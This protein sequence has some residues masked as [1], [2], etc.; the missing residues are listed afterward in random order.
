MTAATLDVERKLADGEGGFQ[1]EEV[2]LP[3]LTLIALE[4]PEN[5]LAPFYLS[6]I[7]RQLQDL[8]FGD[9]AQALVSS[10]SPSILSRIEPED[11]RHL[12]LVPERRTA[13]VRGIELPDGAEAAGKFVRQAVRA[14]PELYFARFVI[15]G[16]GAS[17]EIVLPKLAD[18]MGLPIDRSFVAMVPLGGRHVNHLWKLLAGL[19]I[20]YQK[21]RFQ[22]WGLT[23]L[24]KRNARH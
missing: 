11:V 15:L 12:R 2:P 19:D 6:R 14:Y 1:S 3:A 8:S 4:E 21:T 9:R 10:H 7:T 13:R 22:N 20:P 5:N 16:E 24:K 23:A 18:A 17:E